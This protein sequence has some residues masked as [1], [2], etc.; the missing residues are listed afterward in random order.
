VR[1]AATYAIPSSEASG[2]VSA[3]DLKRLRLLVIAE[4]RARGVSVPRFAREFFHVGR[5]TVYDWL[6]AASQHEPPGPAPD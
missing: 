2:D 5:S 6:A 4:L 1:L 3:E